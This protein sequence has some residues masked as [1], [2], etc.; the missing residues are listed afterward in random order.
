M[1]TIEEAGPPDV[2]PLV[3]AAFGLT[4]RERDVVTHVLQGAG[5]SDIAKA[6]HLSPHTVQDHLKSIFDKAGVRSRKALLARVY[7]D[8][9]HPG[10][11]TPHTLTPSGRLAAA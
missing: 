9:Y 7:F 5:T 10:R 1:V 6:L 2:V 4:G 11:E 3:I 8:H